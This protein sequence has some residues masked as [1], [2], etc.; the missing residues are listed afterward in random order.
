MLFPLRT[1]VVNKEGMN[2]QM[3][4][5][6]EQWSRE[7]CS[8]KEGDAGCVPLHTLDWGCCHPAWHGGQCQGLLQSQTGLGRL[9][10][11]L[12]LH[13]PRRVTEGRC[14]FHICQVGLLP[15]SFGVVSAGE[16]ELSLC[17]VCDC[18]HPATAGFLGIKPFWLQGCQAPSRLM[19]AVLQE[20]TGAASFGWQVGGLSL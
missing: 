8:W 12:L 18:H 11:E 2:K 6:R 15:L 5:E 17:H 4:K 1:I 13:P 10:L 16:K 14:R 3:E 19:S 7:S 9:M 20:I